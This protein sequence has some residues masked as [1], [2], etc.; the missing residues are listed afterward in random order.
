MSVIIVS[1]SK[2]QSEAKIFVTCRSTGIDLRD[3]LKGFETVEIMNF[4]ITK[5]INSSS[6]F[7]FARNWFTAAGMRKLDGPFWKKLMC[8]DENRAMRDISGNPRLLAQLCLTFKETDCFPVPH[9]VR[10][11]DH[12]LSPVQ[13]TRIFPED[14]SYHHLT[15]RRQRQMLASIA[16]EFFE[17]SQYIFDEEE[18]SSRIEAYINGLPP[19]DQIP[20]KKDPK[21]KSDGAIILQAIEADNGILTKIGKRKYMFSYLSF[22]E[23]L[24]AYDIVDNAAAD[25]RRSIPKLLENAGSVRWREVILI[26]ASLLKSTN[27]FF[28]AF[29]NSLDQIT[30]NN[31]KLSEILMWVKKKTNDV[32]N[33]V[34]Y[35]DVAVRAFYLREVIG[36]S[37]IP[38]PVYQ[39]VCKLTRTLDSKLALGQTLDRDLDLDCTLCKA[40]NQI[41]AL[42]YDYMNRSFRGRTGQTQSSS[43]PLNNSSTRRGLAKTLDK[44]QCLARALNLPE[45]R[46]E[47]SSI[48]ISS[49]QLDLQTLQG[50]RSQLRGIMEE[51]RNISDKWSLSDSETKRLSA[52]ITATNLLVRCLEVGYIDQTKRKS[53]KERLLLPP[54][55]TNYGESTRKTKTLGQ[56]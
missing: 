36:I 16:H 25:R 48:Q 34:S 22:R 28:E 42:Y 56:P 14:T 20:W 21:L 7:K 50:Y 18:L 52:F 15:P 32:K 26:T 46:A 8:E 53:I 23:Y 55:K 30:L 13:E 31:E 33:N 47:L 6:I 38:D 41:S 54:P 43:N 1:L 10:I 5:D 40:L 11:Y 37:P 49:Y 45:L 9:R 2:V 29:L 12:A 35:P 17:S 27:A 4:D 24:I 44:A 19:E 3:W 39:T 51:Y